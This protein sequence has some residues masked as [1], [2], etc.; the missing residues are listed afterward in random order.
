MPQKM[1]PD[2]LELIRGKT[3]RV[4]GDLQAIAG[5]GEG[6]AAR[7]QPRPAGRQR[8]RVRLRRHGRAPAWNSPPPLVAGAELK[9]EAIA[10]RLEDGYLD[11]TTLMEHLITQGVPQR[12]AHEMIG[13]LVAVAMQQNIPLAKLPAAELN[14]AHAGL[15]SSAR[16]VLGAANTIAAFKSLGS[17][18]PSMV[19]AQV[20]KWKDRLEGDS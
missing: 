14:A 18:N 6:T 4:I 1:N 10:A 8:A 7:L 15:A 20:A 9:R 17:T 16:S 3:A 12:T 11:A 19:A 13:K 5:A 2:V